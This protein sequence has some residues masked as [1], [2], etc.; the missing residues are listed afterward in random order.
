MPSNHTHHVRLMHAA[1]DTSSIQ[2]IQSACYPLQ[3]LESSEA[4]LAKQALSPHSCWLA[5]NKHGPLGYLFAHPWHDNT[6]LILNRPLDN[7]PDQANTFF[8][9]DLAI[10]PHARN[11]G[12]AQALIQQAMQWAREEN[13][14]KAMLVA[15]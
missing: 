3:L 1:G 2:F 7:L 8:L 13:F 10:H 14:C 4:L 11:Q 12:L 9:H 5:E 15:V 6:L